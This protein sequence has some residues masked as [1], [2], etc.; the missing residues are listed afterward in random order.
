MHEPLPNTPT[1]DTSNAAPDEFPKIQTESS[2][3]APPEDVTD[4]ALW[5]FGLG[6]GAILLFAQLVDLLNFPDWTVWLYRLILLLEAAL[7]LAVSF[8]LKNS[9]KATLLRGLGIL[10]MVLYLITLF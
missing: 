10:V 4:R 8:F 1:H 2:P 7:P 9:K 5:Y 6:I 3:I